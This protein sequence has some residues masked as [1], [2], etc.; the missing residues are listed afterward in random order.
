MF[1]LTYLESRVMRRRSFAV[2]AKQAILCFMCAQGKEEEN[3]RLLQ[4][5]TTIKDL[6]QDI[7]TLLAGREFDF[8]VPEYDIMLK[9]LVITI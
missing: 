8:D 1:A 9:A 2:R 4:N 7:L 5:R 3:I 6:Q